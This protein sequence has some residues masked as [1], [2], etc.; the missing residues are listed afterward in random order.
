MPE[1]EPRA[2]QLGER[3]GDCT[4]QVNE[5]GFDKTLIQLLARAPWLVGSING[6]LNRCPRCGETE[7]VSVKPIDGP[8]V[9]RCSQCDTVY[10]ANRTLRLQRLIDVLDA[11]G[12]AAPVTP[13]LMDELR[14]IRKAMEQS[15]NATARIADTMRR[16]DRDGLPP[17]DPLEETVPSP[18]PIKPKPT[19]EEAVPCTHSS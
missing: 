8:R 4:K 3:L 5:P 19:T 1:F 9:D 10:P 17:S 12:T 6:L 16:W 15:L 11:T 18:K 14:R 13:A 2:Q 7:F